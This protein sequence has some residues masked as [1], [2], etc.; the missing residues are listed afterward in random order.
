ME[1]MEHPDHDLPCADLD[2]L[3]R[4][5]LC[6][7]RSRHAARIR[8]FHVGCKNRPVHLPR[9]IPCALATNFSTVLAFRFLG[10]LSSAGG[11]VTLGMVADMWG[12]DEHHY[13][14]NFVVAASV[15][16]SV[17]APIFG[18][19]IGQ[20]LEWT[21]VFWIAL[22]LGAITQA[23]HMCVPETRTDV[24]MDKEAQR[25]RRSGENVWG[26][27]EIRGT[28]WQRLN[29]R[30]CLQLIWRPYKMLLTEPIVGF[31]SLLSGFSDALIFTG[32]D[33][34][35]MVLDK[36]DFTLVQKG[37]SFSP[38]LISYVLTW[39]SFQI[40]YRRDWYLVKSGAKFTPEHRLWWLCYLV[41]FSSIGLFGFAWCSLGPLHV[42]WIAPLLFTGCIGIANYAI[43]M[44]TIDYSTASYGDFAASATGGNG[45]CRD[46]LAGLAALYTTPFYSNI[47]TGTNFQL[48]I[49]T[50]ILSAVAVLLSIPVYVFY[51]KGEYFRKRSKLA[52]E[53][54]RERE[55]VGGAAKPQPLM[56]EAHKPVLVEEKAD[57]VEKSRNECCTQASKRGEAKEKPA[58]QFLSTDGKACDRH[59]A[60][61]RGRARRT[62]SS[63]D[64]QICAVDH[65][66][67]AK[68]GP[69]KTIPPICI[70]KLPAVNRSSSK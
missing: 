59:V 21:W 66:V 51:V 9:H 14:L 22:I 65:A 63:Q 34:F 29:F 69:K 48:V 56:N 60:A 61:P 70:A 49:P 67:L 41:P 28:V 58:E 7:S 55:E 23:I 3:Q 39:G 44:A 13:A 1:E 32:L 46:F 37:L 10:G 19:F 26:P 17:V 11:S 42:H 12:P 18:G 5:H 6:H 36:W 33:S 68:I 57:M 43:Y 54:E 15:G 64:L 30:H 35:S 25:M 47:A 62:T 24:L 52:M 4:C 31:L 27:N 2:E 38:L 20:Y 45:F 16:G 53:L 50:L 40:I 8:H